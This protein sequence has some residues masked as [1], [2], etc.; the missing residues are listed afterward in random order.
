MKILLAAALLFGLPTAAHDYVGDHAQPNA[1][2]KGV[3][4]G[5]VIGQD[6]KPWSGVNLIL[7]PVGD[8]DYVLP[9]TKTDQRGEYRFQ[10]VCTGKWGVFVEDKEAGYASSGR[11]M[12]WFL[13]GRWSPEVKIT[14]KNLDAQLDVDAPPKGGM[15][16]VH[17]TNSV[18]HTKIS[19]IE[20]EL[21]VSRKQR[22]G[23]SCEN[24]ESS[25]CG[26][27]PFLVPPN[28]DV[29]LHVTSKGFYEWKESVGR[30]KLIHLSA[31]EAMT[32]DVELDPIQ[33]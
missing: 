2:C 33:N 17:L 8:Y 18:T 20:V 26:D 11:H 19:R 22:M 24:S 21:I 23:F 9:R 25:P 3:V 4:H 7:E 10:K 32:I 29:K 27:G 15:L 1:D 14:D 6:H 31:G 28:Q 12:N 16:V 5:V 30:G 13:Y